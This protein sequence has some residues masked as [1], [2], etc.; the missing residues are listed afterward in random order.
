VA[1]AGFE[2]TSI[3][4]TGSE[5]VNSLVSGWFQGFSEKKGLK[6]SDSSLVSKENFSE[7]LLSTG[8]ALGQVT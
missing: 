6:Y 5:D 8:W 4:H 1:N 7:I 2:S 3:S